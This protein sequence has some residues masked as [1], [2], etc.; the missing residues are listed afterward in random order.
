M[1]QT[2]V[3]TDIRCLAGKLYNVYRIITTDSNNFVTAVSSE[4]YTDT[5]SSCGGCPTYTNPPIGNGGYC[6]PSVSIPTTLF[7]TLSGTCLCLDTLEVELTYNAGLSLWEG[8]EIIVCN[9]VS[10]T[11]HVK[12]FCDQGNWWVRIW[13]GSDESIAG[14]DVCL[15][16]LNCFTC[17]PFEANFTGSMSLS[18]CECIGGTISASVIE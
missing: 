2:T 12:L 10:V 4:T 5:G 14:Q 3:N 11:V 18:N 7:C 17:F 6:C 15:Q 1:P 8:Q 16:A 9:L 13:C